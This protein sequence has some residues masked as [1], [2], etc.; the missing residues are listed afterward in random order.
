MDIPFQAI[1]TVYWKH[2]ARSKLQGLKVDM[3]LYEQLKVSYYCK[4]ELFASLSIMYNWQNSQL[5]SFSIVIV[6][7]VICFNNHTFYI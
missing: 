6:Y 1:G 2:G 7:K 5:I 4:K 3:S